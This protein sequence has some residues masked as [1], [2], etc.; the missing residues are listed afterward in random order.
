MW[1]VGKERFGAAPCVFEKF[2]ITV[3]IKIG[4][5]VPDTVGKEYIFIGAVLPKLQVHA[6]VESPDGFFSGIEK[7]CKICYAIISEGHLY[8]PY[9]HSKKSFTV[10]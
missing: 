6:A 1:F 10:L 3:V 9:D 4:L 7:R 5:A 8:Y 2:G